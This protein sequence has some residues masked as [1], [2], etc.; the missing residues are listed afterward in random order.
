MLS[1]IYYFPVLAN[2][3]AE[4]DD[5]ERKGKIWQPRVPFPFSPSLIIGEAKGE[6]VNRKCV[7]QEM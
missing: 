5:R 7:C 4:K 6:S 3:W 1:S 2:H